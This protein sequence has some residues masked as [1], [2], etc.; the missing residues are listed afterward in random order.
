VMLCGGDIP[1]EYSDLGRMGIVHIARGSRDRIYDL[2][3]LERDID[4]IRKAELTFERCSFDGGHDVSVE[5]INSAYGF[6]S[7]NSFFVV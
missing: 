5:Y 2:L 6:L 3:H 1:E 4:R 7:N